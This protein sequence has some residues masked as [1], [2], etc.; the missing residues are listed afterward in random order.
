MLVNALV[1]SKWLHLLDLL[2]QTIGTGEWRV[3]AAA[4]TASKCSAEIVPPGVVYGRSA[5]LHSPV[6]GGVRHDQIERQ[7]P[8]ALMPIGKLSTC[9]FRRV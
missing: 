7:V 4:S 9:S 6:A 1:T 5:S 3:E 2:V 8:A